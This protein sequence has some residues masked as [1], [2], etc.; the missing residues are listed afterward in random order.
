MSDDMK[1]VEELLREFTPRPA[2]PALRRRILAAADASRKEE[3]FLSPGQWRA[4]ATFGLLIAAAVGGDALLAG[5]AGRGARGLLATTWGAG[6]EAQ[7][8]DPDMIREIAGRDRNLEK[9]IL[10]RLTAEE[11][12][13]R[14]HRPAAASETGK[15]REVDDVL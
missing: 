8:I 11:K 5:P 10:E 13:T 1:P 6:A 15:F 3:T 2:P 12:S 7:K 4:A 9:L 14:A